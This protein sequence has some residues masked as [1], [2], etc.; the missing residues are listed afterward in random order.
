MQFTTAIYQENI[1]QTDTIAFWATLLST[2]PIYAIHRFAVDTHV[3]EDRH[4]TI[5]YQYQTAAIT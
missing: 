4:S 1:F 3:V 5:V 2:V